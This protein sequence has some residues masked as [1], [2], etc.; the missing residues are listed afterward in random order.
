MF[1]D[2]CGQQFLPKESVCT[3]CGVAPS[4][5]W[6]QLAGLATLTVAIVWNSLLAL[7]FLSRLANGDQ[8]PMFRTWLR[9]NDLVASYGWAALAMALLVWSFWARRGYTILR[10]EWVARVFLILLL[11]AGIAAAPLPWLPA[12]LGRVYLT[13]TH[14]YPGLAPTLA[15]AMIVSVVGLLCMSSETRDSLLGHGRVLTL[16]SLGLLVLILGLMT[17]GWSATYH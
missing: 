6:L 15:W 8:V 5:H 11:L 16:V 17:L 7:L 13:L 14:N 10:R 3:K 9:L 4:R 1:C 2:R 12:R